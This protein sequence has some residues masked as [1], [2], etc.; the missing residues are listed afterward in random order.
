MINNS[1]TYI[2]KHKVYTSNFLYIY[3]QFFI[4][5]TSNSSLHIPA[6]LHC[7][8][9]SN[10]HTC[11]HTYININMHMNTRYRSSLRERRAW[12]LA[13]SRHEP[14]AVLK[15][16]WTRRTTLCS[17]VCVCVCVCCVCVLMCSKGARLHPIRNII[18]IFECCVRARV[19]VCVC[20]FCVCVVCFV[21]VRFVCLCVLCVC[22]C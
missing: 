4:V 22:V 19:R 18:F 11:K 9:S 20:V 16:C 6:I 10:R 7:G 17:C 8:G 5:Y 3:Q 21:C 1:F 2:Y 15:W 14:V 12:Q 13:K